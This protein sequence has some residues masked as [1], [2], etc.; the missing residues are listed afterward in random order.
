MPGWNLINLRASDWIAE[1]GNPSWTKP[2][3][4]LRFR[5]YDSSSSSYSLDGFY[6]GVV[7]MPAVVF[8]FDD[9]HISLYTQAY[10]YMDARN[11]RGTGYIITDW[12]GGGTQISWSQLQNIYASGWTIG[13]HTKSH[14][15]MPDL[16]LNDQ[17]AEFYAAR[18]ALN[19]HGLMDVDYVAY[20][21]GEYNSDTL[22][23]M[24]NLGMHNGRPLLNFMNISPLMR[25]FEIGQKYIGPGTA[26]ATAENLVI[27]AISRQEILV[28]TFHDISTSPTGNGWYIDRFQAFVDYCIQQGIP[29]LTMDDLYRLQSE[30]IRIPSAI[31]EIP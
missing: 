15:H 4:R 10:T 7:A 1:A 3:L 26:L 29:F 9:A 14:P 20:P 19:S 30:S 18:L 24:A 21:F 16:S 5:I 12:V 25:P 22:A 6:S 27:T 31:E 13:N 17:I 2:I 28:I 23:S 11:V 8:T